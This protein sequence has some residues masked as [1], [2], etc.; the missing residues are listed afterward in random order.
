A[1]ATGRLLAEYPSRVRRAGGRLSLGAALLAV[2]LAFGGLEVA[3]D[4]SS[5]LAL[6]P[7]ASQENAEA[8][9]DE[10]AP[11]REGDPAYGAFYF[12]NNAQ[13]A[14][15]G[16]ALGATFGVGTLLLLLYNGVLLGAT[17]ALVAARGSLRALLSYVAPH[18]GLELAAIVIAA[19]GGFGLAQALLAPGWQRRQDALRDAA[20]EALPLALGSAVLLGVA[21]LAEGWLSPK[22]WPL[23]WKLAIGLCL[24]LCLALY[25]C[26]PAPSAAAEERI[27]PAGEAR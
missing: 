9:Q 8:F 23:H 18:G 12:T 2:G 10:G 7:T 21:G 16:F 1:R 17:I 14:A 26:L 25:L 13:V 27:A 4:P 6:L 15:L 19:A 20:R 5:A 24:D 3:R 22:P 11:P